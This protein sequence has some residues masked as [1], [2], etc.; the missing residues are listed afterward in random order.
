[1]KTRLSGKI[2]DRFETL[3]CPVCGKI[4]GAILVVGRA[5]FKKDPCPRCKHTVVIGKGLT[6]DTGRHK[7]ETKIGPGK[8]TQ[9]VSP[10]AENFEPPGRHKPLPR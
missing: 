3:K 9:M 1:M 2:D 10:A 7:M 6:A 5:V 4:L 8:R